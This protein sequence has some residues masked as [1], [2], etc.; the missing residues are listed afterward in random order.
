MSQDLTDEQR[1]LVERVEKLLRLAGSNTNEAEAASATAKAMDLLAQANLDMSVVDESGE[2]SGRRA[3]EKLAGGHYEY[4]RSLWS[5]ISDL[6]FCLHWYQRSWVPRL[7]K[8]AKSERIKTEWGR[9]HILRGQH[10]LVGR[11]V[12]IAGTKAMV[13][14]LLQTIERL[15]RD[16]LRERLGQE[17]VNTQMRSRWAVS[18]R[19]GIAERVGEKIYERRRELLSEERRQAREAEARAAAAGMAGAS[20][21]T[22]VTIASLKKTERDA[23]MDFVYGEGFSAKQAARQAAWAAEQRA[24]EEAHTAWAAANPEEAARREAEARAA[25]READARASRR[26]YRAPPQGKD[27]D[28]SAY[29][30]GYEAG[31]SVGLD[32]QAERSRSSGSIGHTAGRIGHG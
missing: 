4:E 26:R 20:T 13:S 23:N 25:A 31:D 7:S 30:A 15:T 16:R 5:A 12:N 6:N 21:E 8:D 18:F 29:R 10:R 17:S 9:N 14:Y 27:R 32:P 3:E 19:E 2:G 1:S 24:Q 28:W 22:G 11:Q